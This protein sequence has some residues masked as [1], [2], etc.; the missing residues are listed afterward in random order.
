MLGKNNLVLASASK[1]VVQKLRSRVRLGYGASS[2]TAFGTH[3]REKNISELA[4]RDE[5]A[6][7]FQ[8][9]KIDLGGLAMPVV[10]VNKSRFK[11]RI[12]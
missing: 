9:R 8:R 10:T 3:F 11:R 5:M 2:S 4:F 6:E 7:K 1:F 12:I